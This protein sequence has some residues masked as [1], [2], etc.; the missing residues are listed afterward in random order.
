MDQ[1]WPMAGRRPSLVL[2]HR[3]RRENGE[4]R[5][6]EGRSVVLIGPDFDLCVRVSLK[7]E[8]RIKRLSRPLT[9][10]FRGISANI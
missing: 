4:L 7:R 9:S 10:G 2:G 8:T 5:K 3:G 6:G 1:R